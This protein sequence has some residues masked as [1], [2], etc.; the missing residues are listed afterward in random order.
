MRV[1]RYFLVSG[2]AAVVAGSLTLATQATV[3]TAAP[4]H[5]VTQP[6]ARFL[7]Q[8]RA[9]LVSYLSVNQ[10]A[11]PVTSGSQGTRT[12]NEPVSAP[13]NTS[14]TGSYN[15]SGYADV[16]K[17]ANTFTKVTGQWKTP[18]V[19]CTRE[20]QLTSNFVGIDGFSN[21]TVE[22]AGTYSW[23]FLGQATYFTFY[24]MY[25]AGTIVVGN[26]V[27]AGD[28]ITAS[29][30]RAGTS[31]NLAVTDATRP[32]NSFSVT[33]TC[34]TCQNTSVEWIAERPSFTIGIAPLAD[35][36]TWT[37]SSASQTAGGKTGTI[38][39]YPT[40]YKIDMV[41]ATGTYPL[42]LT[43]GLNNA[44]SEFLTHWTNSY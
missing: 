2:S 30:S 7:T 13:A 3:T 41:D 35:Y 21:G 25:P 31:Y 44:G 28:K 18:K 24:E 4:D 43:S 1:L 22:Q 9:A 11:P 37:L 20:D 16:S 42:S 8:A 34:T 33:K 14:A 12:V 40:Y 26:S 27:R 19:H 5:S 29:V 15:W 39:G 10:S 38:T 23:C 17:T 32:V 36:K 6:S